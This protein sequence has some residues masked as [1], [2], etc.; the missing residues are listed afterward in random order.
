MRIAKSGTRT[1][2]IVVTSQVSLT[3]EPQSSLKRWNFFENITLKNEKVAVESSIRLMGV[4]SLDQKADGCLESQKVQEPRAQLKTTATL[5]IEPEDFL[6]CFFF[7][8][9]GSNEL[10]FLLSLSLAN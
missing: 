9:E 3:T 10:M 8:F 6:R 1:S 4:S 7:F 2:N 5:C